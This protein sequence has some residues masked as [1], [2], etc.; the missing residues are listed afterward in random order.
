MSAETRTALQAR[1]DALR[2][3]KARLDADHYAAHPTVRG[4]D[5]L[6]RSVRLEREMN[7]L[8]YWIEKEQ[9]QP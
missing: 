5:Y 7:D 6:R 2:A 9:K 4:A 3:E 1:L 8:L